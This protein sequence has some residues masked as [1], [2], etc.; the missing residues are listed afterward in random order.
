[1]V[2]YRMRKKDI[3]FQQM[4]FFPFRAG[5]YARA[6]KATFRRNTAARR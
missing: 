3:C 4:S 1:M 6:L 5:G 2:Q